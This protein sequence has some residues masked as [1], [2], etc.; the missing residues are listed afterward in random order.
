[1]AQSGLT[2]FEVATI[3]VARFEVARVEVALVAVAR[4]CSTT[5]ELVHTE[6]GIRTG[7]ELR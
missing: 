3:E 7:N 4:V 6:M 5:G 1:M 2:R